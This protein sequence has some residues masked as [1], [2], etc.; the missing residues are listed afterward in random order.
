MTAFDHILNQNN[1]LDVLQRAYRA[2]R[3]PHGLIFAGPVGVGKAT[4]ARALGQ[5][6]LC[7]KPDDVTP[8]GVCASCKLLDA[9]T[10]PDF[11]VVYRQLIR[12]DKESSKARD[13]PIDVIRQY[14]VAPAGLKSAMGRGKVFLVEE[15]EL[16]NA[17]AQ[18][19]MLKT[20]E[21]PA[22]RTLIV[23][24]T[25]QPAALLPTIRSRCQLVRFVPLDQGLVRDQLAK[26]GIE[27][28]QA[29][30]ASQL[31]EGSLGMALRWIEDGVVAAAQDLLA[32]LDALL[33]GKGSGDLQDWFRRAA[34]AYAEKQLQ[35][36][37]LASKDQAT[38]EGLAVYLHLAASDLRRRLRDETDPEGL[39]RLC[40]AIDAILRAEEYL[41]SN[42]NIAL[43]FQQLVLTLRGLFRPMPAR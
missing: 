43:V 16:M 37:D 3:L 5:L 17:S 39:E 23:L 4:T 12:L 22:G 8:C 21:E 20:L 24:L 13:L 7:E 6:F 1:A 25:D 19:A 36:D 10:H 18:N 26:R 32:K 2:D 34:E 27:P 33:S 14:L 11:H 28:K 40:E 15:A 9:G 35:R 42:V 30:Q 41:E 29:A 38:R 31:A